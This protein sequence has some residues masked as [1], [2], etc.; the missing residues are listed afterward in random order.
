MMAN[1]DLETLAGDLRRITVPTVLVVGDKDKAV[2]PGDVEQV[3]ELIPHANIE[4]L[5]GSA[6]SRMKRSRA[7]READL[8][9]AA[10]DG[11]IAAPTDVDFR[12]RK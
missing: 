12:L 2:P 10:R 4:R 1:W 3:A 8:C 9:S 7:G 5:P 6:T 11:V